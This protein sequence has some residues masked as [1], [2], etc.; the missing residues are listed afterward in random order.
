M[1]ALQDMAFVE[2]LVSQF[3]VWFTR[4]SMHNS[5]FEFRSCV[6]MISGM[7]TAT[8]AKTAEALGVVESA[9]VLLPSPSFMLSSSIFAVLALLSLTI[10]AL[11]SPQQSKPQNSHCRELF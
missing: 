2:T 6:F 10:P 5:V 11:L 1:D 7:V 9:G 3:V 4:K 8:V